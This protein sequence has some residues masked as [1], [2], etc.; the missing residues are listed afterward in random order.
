MFLGVKGY[1]KLLIKSLHLL[2]WVVSRNT[3]KTKNID[4]MEKSMLACLDGLSGAEAAWVNKRYHGH[5]TL[6]PIM[7]S[8]VREAQIN[9]PAPL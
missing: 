9:I 8:K 2:P 7:L 5:R 3:P 1:N 6:L 4:G